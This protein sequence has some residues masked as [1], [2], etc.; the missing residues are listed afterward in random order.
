MSDECST[1]QSI[2]PLASRREGMNFAP[3]KKRVHEDMSSIVVGDAR[4]ALFQYY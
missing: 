1:P 3:V 2:K 4:K